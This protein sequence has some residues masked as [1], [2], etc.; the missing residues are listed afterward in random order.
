MM[1]W[2]FWRGCSVIG[3][4]W[5]RIGWRNGV[6]LE[7]DEYDWESGKMS[8]TPDVFDDGSRRLSLLEPYEL[9]DFMAVTFLN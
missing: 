8:T 9:D 1:L 7:R 4:F 2:G 6:G 5:C 3:V